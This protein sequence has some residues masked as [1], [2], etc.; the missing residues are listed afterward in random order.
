[1]D[2]ENRNSNNKNTK[3]M[4]AKERAELK[5][6]IEELERKVAQRDAQSDKLVHA[7]E[8]LAKT[9]RELVRENQALRKDYKEHELFQEQIKKDQ[10]GLRIISSKKPS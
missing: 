10:P 5:Q 6:K 4:N 1:M 8:S 9:N 3:N 7:V 2:Q